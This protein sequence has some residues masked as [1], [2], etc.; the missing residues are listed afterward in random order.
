MSGRGLYNQF[1][2]ELQHFSLLDCPSNKYALI[3]GCYIPILNIE[4][5][6]VAL[7]T[8]HRHPCYVIHCILGALST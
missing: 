5:Y 3:T 8:C 4:T 2:L 6:S 7:V 1:R